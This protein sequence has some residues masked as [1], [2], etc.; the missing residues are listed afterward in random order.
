[1]PFFD[2]AGVRIHYEIHG[3][4]PPVLLLHGFAS[5]GRVNWVS[6]G[7]TETIAGA[8]CTAVVMDLRGHGRSDRPH[9]AVAYGAVTMAED[10][11]RLLDHLGVDVAVVMG[12]SLGARVAAFL[13]IRHPRRVRALILAGMAANLLRGLDDAAEIAAA[14]EAE[15]I[16]AVRGQKARAFRQFAERTGSDLK[17]LAACMRAG[18]EPVPAAALAELS[19]PV[20]ITVGDKDA[21]AGPPEPLAAVIP[22][23]EV[24]VLP[25]RD[26]MNAV[27][28]AGHKR[29]V[30]DFLHRV[31]GGGERR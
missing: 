9:D 30:T 27:G 11:A 7:W 16:N 23:A 13:A 5:N 18:R 20:L 12:Y 25:G 6:T 8:G 26:H 1:M 19:M 14:L 2:S 24:V 15:N 31:C 4:G 3:A 29:A 21:I 28:D 17:A 10:A 22:G